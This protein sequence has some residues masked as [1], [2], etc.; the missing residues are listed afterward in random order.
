[1]G[2]NHAATGMRHHTDIAKTMVDTIKVIPM[3]K[4]AVAGI[5]VTTIMIMPRPMA[6]AA[7]AESMVGTNM[8]MP[9]AAWAGMWPRPMGLV[10]QV[11]IRRARRD[12]AATMG[13]P[14]VQVADMTMATNGSPCK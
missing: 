3:A 14:M 8:T 10:P 6:K 2:R 12:A 5:M 7:V 11:K 13:M 9:M 1:M 4:A